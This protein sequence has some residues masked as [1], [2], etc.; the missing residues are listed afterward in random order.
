MAVVEEVVVVEVVEVNVGAE[1][2]VVVAMLCPCVPGGASADNGSGEG[3]P[4]FTCKLPC[5]HQGP[6]L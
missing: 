4:C 1:G 3:H 2:D 6:P 5:A